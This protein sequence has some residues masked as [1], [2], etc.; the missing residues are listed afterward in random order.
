MKVFVKGGSTQGVNLGQREF[1]AQG[2][3]GSVYAR[4]GT[5]YKIYHD[6][7]DMLPQGKI[8]ELSALTDP[9]IIRPQQILVDQKGNPVGYTTRF[10]KD[11][12]VLCQLFPKAFRNR[13][14]VTPEMVQALV[15]KLQEGVQHVHQH[16]LLIVDMNEM[17]FLVDHGFAEVYFIDVDSYQTPHYPAPAIME[18]I[19]DWQVQK[20]DWTALSDWYSF[21]V[22]TFQMF[23]GMH[24]FRGKYTG[25]E[26]KFKSKLP[27]DAPGDT[28]A[29]TRRRMQGNIS[30]LHPEVGYPQGPTYPLSV[31]PSAYKA[32]YEAVFAQ[33]KRCLPPT[34][35][36]AAIVVMPIIKLVKGTQMLDIVEI[37]GYEGT[38]THTWSSG[39]NLVVATN[40][41]IWVGPNRVPTSGTTVLGC[42]FSPR[43][44]SPVLAEASPTGPALTNLASRATIDFM[45]QAQ[46]TV[47]YDG[48]LYVRSGDKVYE[49]ILT[50]AGGKVIASTRAVANILPH[51]SRLYQG[52]VIQNM[53]GSVFV[54]LL[55]GTGMAQQVRVKEL[56][57]YKVLDARYDGG[58]LMVVGAKKSGKYDRLVFRFEGD[59]YDVREVEDITP[60]GLNF[61]TLD[62]GVCICLNE[63][64]KLEL[65]SSR[66][67]SQGLKIVEDKALKGDMILGKQGGQLI[68]SQGSRVYTMRMR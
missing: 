58:V 57:K 41:G 12:Y 50:D 24:P 32:W 42:A 11:A 34:D 18:S 39:T 38:V 1:V 26:D 27:S 45:L 48:R 43:G 5:T 33:G 28:F 8:Q 62:S 10:I 37:R 7:K 61:V 59:Q 31:I 9:R 55:C 67:G 19:R 47:S 29:I 23:I 20:H 14:G 36:G 3:Q 63:E 54:S 56:D 49:V 64:E 65:C 25:K 6:P 21:A 35:F 66:R 40:K 15:R 16:G 51:A 2:G 53:L 4:G 52:V 17:N 13:E 60:T 22:L 44:D 46:E 30:V 68:F